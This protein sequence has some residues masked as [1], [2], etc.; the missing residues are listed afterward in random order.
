MAHAAI[1]WLLQRP[2]VA[3]V[4]VGARTPDQI[5]KNAEAFDFVLPEQVV[6]ELAEITD[7]LKAAMGAN[8]DMWRTAS[9]FR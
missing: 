2:A 6:A 9:R 5:R 4:L 1:L 7:S 3:A 8:P